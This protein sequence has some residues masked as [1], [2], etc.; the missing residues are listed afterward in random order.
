MVYF[1]LCEK[2][3]KLGTSMML[4]RKVLSFGLMVPLLKK[5]HD[6]VREHE[7]KPVRMIYF[8]TLTDFSLCIAHVADIP[9]YFQKIGF[10]RF[11]TGYV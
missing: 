3:E 8:K 5:I 1:E 10:S 7:E 2:L 4:T 9:L 11:Q 6:R